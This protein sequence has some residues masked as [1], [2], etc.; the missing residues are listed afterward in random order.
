MGFAG[1][2]C[3]AFA[4]W[5]KLSG[6]VPMIGINSGYCFAGNAAILACCDVIIATEDSYIGMAG[7]AMIEGGGLGVV[8]PEEI[9]PIEVQAAN[10]V[11]DVVVDDE[12]GAVA[13]AKQY[14]GY[15]QGAVAEWAAADQTL[16]RDVVPENRK[17]I[18]DMR[19]VLALVADTGSVLE[20]RPAHAPGMITA[21]ARIEGRPVGVIANVPT[22][23][24]GAIDAEGADV[25]ARHLQLC[26]A[27]G[28]P[29]VVLCDTPGFMVGPEAE[30]QAGVRRFSRMFLAGA[31]L[32]VPILTVITRK[33]YGLGAQAMLGGHLK[34]PLLTIGWPTAELGPMGLEGA[35]RLGFRRELDA[36]DDPV[37]RQQ[38][39]DGLIE[40]AYANAQGLNAAS[41]AEIDDV[42]D[43]ADTRSRLVA[44]LR[45]AGPVTKSGRFI[46]AR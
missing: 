30:T 12:A 32:S 31:A 46:D 7:P 25:A 17:R 43:P 21:L 38:R 9:G 37:E 2:D 22:H 33:A 27:Y 44:A 42:I 16:L 39:E 1:L 14:L 45:A 41:F 13:V 23:L 4:Y 8:A 18:Y 15:T 10:G 5:G 24:G 6:L 34:V 28:L 36:I 26:D 11:V 29:V 3:L 40:L 20:L 19:E 35:V